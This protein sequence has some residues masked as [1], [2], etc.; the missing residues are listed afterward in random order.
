[1][2]K[3]QT[4]PL[5][6]DDSVQA[7]IAISAAY[8][9]SK[10]FLTA[11]ELNIFSIIES[12]ERTAKEISIE[13]GTDESATLKLLN[14]LC[15]M[16]FLTKSDD[17]FRNTKATRRFLVK[18]RPEYLGNLMYHTYMWNKWDDLT[19]VIRHGKP[20]SSYEELQNKPQHWIEAFVDS[21]HWR[22]VMKAP[23][24]IGLLDLH[25]I[26]SILDLGCNSGIFSMELKK[27]KPS[28]EVTAFDIPKIVLETAKHFQRAG[29]END[30]KLL[31]GNMFAGEFGKGYDAVFI[32]DT[33]TKLNFN[34]NLQLLHKIFDSVNRGGKIIVHDVIIDDDR[35]KPV[36]ATV[37]SIE[38]LINTKGGEVFTET[39]IWVLLNESWFSNVQRIKTPFDT[40]LIIGT[41]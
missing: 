5:I 41:R 19:E 4:N 35:I 8:R 6:S 10:I 21:L 40:S 9:Q 26:D 1:M 25:G 15:A 3:N 14:A 39:D 17:K 13:A 12:E 24:I 20:T 34:T 7:I 11:C 33:L 30:I 16:N 27:A 29:M 18:S 36:S 32:S 38:N 31:S 22:N 23:D 37:E 28:M 2:K